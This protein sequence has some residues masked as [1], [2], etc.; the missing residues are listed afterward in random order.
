MEIPDE[1]ALRQQAAR[2]KMPAAEQMLLLQDFERWAEQVL[3]DTAWAYYRSAA[4]EER[5]KKIEYYI[6]FSSHII[7]FFLL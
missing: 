6:W 2:E 5:C 7:N 4:D 3:S 1:S